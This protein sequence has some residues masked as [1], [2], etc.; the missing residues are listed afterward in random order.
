MNH[1]LPSM[2]FCPIVGTEIDCVTCCVVVDVCI[3]A[4]KESVLDEEFLNNGDWRKICRKCQYHEV[5]L[6]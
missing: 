1:D 3:G 2:P 4:V 5:D 6:K